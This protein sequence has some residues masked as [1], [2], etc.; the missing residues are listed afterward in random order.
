MGYGRNRQVPTIVS[1]F[2]NHII[3]ANQTYCSHLCMSGDNMSGAKNK[4]PPTVAVHAKVNQPL[5]TRLHPV[6]GFEPV[7]FHPEE[8]LVQ[9]AINLSSYGDDW[10]L[11]WPDP[12][13]IC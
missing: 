4:R 9:L 8:H 6:H 12:H 7:D 10:E 11:F 2:K 3:D 5:Q 13:V 1:L